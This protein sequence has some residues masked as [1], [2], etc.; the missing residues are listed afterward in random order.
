MDIC[1][2]EQSNCTDSTKDHLEA[3]LFHT[4]KVWWLNNNLVHSLTAHY[5]HNIQT[6]AI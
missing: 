1:H 6:C 4:T 2:S 3:L 5:F